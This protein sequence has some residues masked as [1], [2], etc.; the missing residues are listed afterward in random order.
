MSDRPWVKSVCRPL[1]LAVT[2]PG[3]NPSHLNS[4]GYGEDHKIYSPQGT[5]VFGCCLLTRMLKASLVWLGWR[6]S[7]VSWLCLSHS[8]GDIL[9]NQFQGL[10]KAMVRNFS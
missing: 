1:E 3:S 6:V 10:E 5:N 2:N 9:K 8:F 7:S 4:C